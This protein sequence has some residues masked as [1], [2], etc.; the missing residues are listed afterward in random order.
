VQNYDNPTGELSNSKS[1]IHITT[2]EEPTMIRRKHLL[3]WIRGA[4]QGYGR[5]R[6]LITVA[7]VLIIISAIVYAAS[8]FRRRHEIWATDPHFAIHHYYLFSAGPTKNRKLVTFYR[9]M[10]WLS[11][12]RVEEDYKD[13]VDIIQKSSSDKGLYLT[14]FSDDAFPKD[15]IDDE[16]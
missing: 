15:W 13:N 9:P 2:R 6:L 3:T 16:I 4:G 12:G 11:G 7:S 8:F 5:L 10:I 1:L 14:E